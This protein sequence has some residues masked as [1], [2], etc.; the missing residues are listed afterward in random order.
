MDRPAGPTTALNPPAVPLDKGDHRGWQER[1]ASPDYVRTSLAAA[2]VLGAA[3]GRFY[4]DVQLHCVNLL[5]T[6]PEGCAARCAYCGLSRSRLGDF[7]RK[8]FIRVEWPT[9]ATEEVVERLA[10]YQ[11][12][13]YRVCLSMVTHPRAYDDIVAIICR[14]RERVDMP[15]SA[16]IAPQLFDAPR[17][18]ALRELGVDMVGIGLDAA[19]ERVFERTRGV[20]V[21]G[22]LSWGRYWQTMEGAR[23]VFGPFRVNAHIMVGIGE[24]DADLVETFRRLRERQ[25]SAYLFSFY[26]EEGS[27]MARRR[28]PSLVRFRRVQLVK[29]LLEKGE[30]GEGQISYNK[31]GRIVRLEVALSLLE[32]AVATGEPFLTGGC[33]DRA[34]QLVCTRPFGSYRPGEPFRDFPFRPLEEDAVRIRKELRLEQLGGG[35]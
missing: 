11:R 17:L 16:L 23:E 19:S 34:G 31:E 8:S 32:R 22:P 24:S 21:R 20:G 27:A 33:P 12:E 35:R 30:M 29:Y 5:L 9:L 4:R 28:K 7:D 2:M 6:Y 3:R 10:R 13:V 1:G 25:V 26:P 14:L 15:L 18:A